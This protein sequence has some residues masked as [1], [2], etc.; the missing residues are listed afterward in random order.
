MRHDV[1][2]ITVHSSN[3]LVFVTVSSLQE[4]LAPGGIIEYVINCK[5]YSGVIPAGQ[6]AAVLKSIIRPSRSSRSTMP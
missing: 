2:E 1:F 4:P 5:R 6:R 3:V